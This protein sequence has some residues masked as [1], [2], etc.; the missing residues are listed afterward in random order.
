LLEAIKAKM[1][2]A[3]TAVRKMVSLNPE[4]ITNVGAVGFLTNHL[5]VGTSV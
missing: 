1:R 3:H 5:N 2:R 4:Q